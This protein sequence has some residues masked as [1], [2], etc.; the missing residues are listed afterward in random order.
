[1]QAVLVLIPIFF[2][3]LS[4]S[5]TLA[6]E[7]EFKFSADNEYGLV[8]MPIDVHITVLSIRAIRLPEQKIVGGYFNA[9]VI[10]SK[11]PELRLYRLG[12]GKLGSMFVIKPGIYILQGYWT[13]WRN[14]RDAYMSKTPLCGALVP[15]E[16]KSGVISVV[17]FPFASSSSLSELINKI[18][19]LKGVTAPLVTIEPK[20]ML[21]KAGWVKG[22][23]GQDCELVDGE[24]LEFVKRI[25]M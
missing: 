23:E 6:A 13:S 7:K 4:T 12:E 21:K 15:F 22:K 25:S 18:E 24:I 16:V 1:M 19:T 5:S 20:V 11:C 10:G 17:S 8:A 2:L 14:S 9:C 3:F